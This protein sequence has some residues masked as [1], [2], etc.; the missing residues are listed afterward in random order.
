MAQLLLLLNPDLVLSPVIRNEY[1]H[2]LHFF[3]VVN[4]ILRWQIGVWLGQVS[5]VPTHLLLQVSILVLR[6]LWVTWASHREVLRGLNWCWTFG[7]LETS[8]IGPRYSL[9]G[10][11]VLLRSVLYRSLKVAAL[12]T[13]GWRLVKILRLTG[14]SLTILLGRTNRRHWNAFTRGVGVHLAY[15]LLVVAIWTRRLLHSITTWNVCI[16]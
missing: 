9:L 14:H 11:R 16:D 12:T 8:K 7:L 10:L 3:A 5:S 6:H 4:L 2:V 13:L 1:S 15:H